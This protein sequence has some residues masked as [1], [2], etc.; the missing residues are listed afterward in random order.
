MDAQAGTKR[1]KERTRPWMVLSLAAAMMAAG[2]VT[3]LAAQ[4]AAHGTAETGSQ[5]GNAPLRIT[6]RVYNFP[7]LPRSLLSNAE[8]T[9]TMI[10]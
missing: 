10:F 7:K 1:F 8:E 3:R 5:S 2:A 4:P 9:A 6:L